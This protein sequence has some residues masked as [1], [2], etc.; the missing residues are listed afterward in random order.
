SGI[1]SDGKRDVM[2][3]ACA[4][5]RDGR[6]DTRFVRNPSSI[7]QTPS[8]LIAD[9]SSR[10]VARSNYHGEY[11]LVATTLV[12]E[13]LHIT[14]SHGDLFVRQYVGDGLGEDVWPLL[15]EQRGEM[16]LLL[17]LLVDG[18]R[19]LTLLDQAANRA[20]PDLDGHAVNCSHLR[21]GEDIY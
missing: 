17:C 12:V 3:G 7:G 20:I 13:I 9:R 1:E 5:G 2:P 8:A 4:F 10:D 14:N 16:A 19:L 6:T 21:Q 15:I 11:E 18:L